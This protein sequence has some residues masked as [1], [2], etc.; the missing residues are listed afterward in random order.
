MK[1][2]V[3]LVPGGAP[4]VQDLPAHA[5]AMDA[6]RAA[7]LPPDLVVVLRAGVPLPEDEPLREGD[8]VEL[9]RVVSG[10]SEG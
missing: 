10:G 6:I 5:T 7:G 9:V 2:T 4:T 1:V 3:R 8:T